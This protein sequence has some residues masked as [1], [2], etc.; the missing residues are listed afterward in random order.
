MFKYEWNEQICYLTMADLK[1]LSG[2]LL[3]SYVEFFVSRLICS[4]WLIDSGLFL[5]IF[6]MKSVHSICDDI[7][8]YDI[9]SF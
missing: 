9:L 8:K 1:G 2:L 7:R 6:P 5:V 4:G 3:S